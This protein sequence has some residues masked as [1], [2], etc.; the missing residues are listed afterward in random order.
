MR[1]R[2]CCWHET[3]KK[4]AVLV[5]GYGSNLQAIIDAIEDEQLPGTQIAVVVSDC[6]NA[7]GLERAKRHGIPAVH[8][9]YPPRSEGPEARRQ[10]DRELAQ[11]LKQ[12]EIDWVVLAGWLRLLSAAFLEH[13]PRRVVNLHPALPGQF[14]G[15]NAIERAFESYQA[16]QARTTGVMVHLVPDENMDSGPLVLSEPVPI[17]PRRHV[18]IS[19][20]A[21]PSQRTHRPHQSVAP[22]ARRVEGD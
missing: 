15:L 4:L 7:Y 13:F 10:K 18:G 22:T 14:P 3:G 9:P 20:P 8:F 1:K 12:Q 21:H 5:S 2:G 6:G 19:D 17:H 16:G 11:L